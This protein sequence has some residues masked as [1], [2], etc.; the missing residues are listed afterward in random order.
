MSLPKTVK[1]MRNLHVYVSKRRFFGF[2]PQDSTLLREY[3]HEQVVD[4]VS[5]AF[6]STLSDPTVFFDPTINESTNLLI[7]PDHWDN[8]IPQAAWSLRKNFSYIPFAFILHSGQSLEAIKKQTAPPNAADVFTL[9]QKGHYPPPNPE[10]VSF[11]T[12][13]TKTPD[14]IYQ[15]ILAL[16][17]SSAAL[18][19]ASDT[20]EPTMTQTSTKVQKKPTLTRSPSKK[21]LEQ[22]PNI[23]S[24]HAQMNTIIAQKIEENQAV[25]DNYYS[26]QELAH[27]AEETLAHDRAWAK[28]KERAQNLS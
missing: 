8:K 10:N 12:M 26:E 3:T 13:D 6:N 16:K 2:D 1:Q 5:H 19:G 7:V 14:H 22:E 11:F 27:Q 18:R 20:M 17:A 21:K 23:P 28:I 4:A 24:W 25:L 15:Q 9:T